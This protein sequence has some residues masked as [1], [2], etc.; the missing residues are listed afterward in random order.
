MTGAP[1]Q[2]MRRSNSRIGFTLVELL[3]VIGITQIG[4]THRQGPKEMNGTAVPALPNSGRIWQWSFGLE[5]DGK[6]YLKLSTSC[7]MPKMSQLNNKAILSDL[8]GPVY[9][10][11]GHHVTGCNVLYGNGAVKWVP[12]SALR[13]SAGA[14]LIQPADAGSFEYNTST[15]KKFLA[16][17]KF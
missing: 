13:D 15:P 7:V 3:V 16:F 6:K 9:V 4:Y 14:S 1:R 8:L 2:D 12:N 17:D 11:N 5:A 10:H